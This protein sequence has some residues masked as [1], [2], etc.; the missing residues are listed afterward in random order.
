MFADAYKNTKPPIKE[1]MHP[2][3]KAAVCVMQAYITGCIT[4]DELAQI[5]TLLNKAGSNNMEA[6]LYGTH[7]RA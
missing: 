1:K 2:L 7:H 6:Q 5:N 4:A 3:D